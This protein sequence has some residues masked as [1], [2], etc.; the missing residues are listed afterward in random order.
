MARTTGKTRISAMLPFAGSVEAPDAPNIRVPQSLLR[1]VTPESVDAFLRR[2]VDVD[3]VLLSVV[4]VHSSGA[5]H[6]VSRAV[7]LMYAAYDV[8][9]GDSTEFIGFAA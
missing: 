5:D 4:H 6:P 8:R 1:L 2:I 7:A 9:V 3:A